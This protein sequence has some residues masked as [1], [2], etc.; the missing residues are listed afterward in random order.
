MNLSYLILRLFNKVIPAG[1]HIFH[2]IGDLT[3]YQMFGKTYNDEKNILA[4]Q[5]KSELE[6]RT[7]AIIREVRD[8]YQSDTARLAKFFAE[9]E[10]AINEM[11]K[12]FDRILQIQISEFSFRHKDIVFEIR[13][14]WISAEVLMT[15]LGCEVAETA[16]NMCIERTKISNE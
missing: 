7:R 8:S 5:I 11:K 14:R 1:E 13:G 10:N 12:E 3:V 15:N 2:N 16:L 4:N 6:E 9:D